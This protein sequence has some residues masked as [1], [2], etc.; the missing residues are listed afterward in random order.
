VSLRDVTR[1]FGQRTVLDGL[2]LA[3]APGQ[4]TALMGP[5]ASG[6][7]TVAR[8]VLGLDAPDTGRVLGREGLRF[9]AV[10]QE[11][12]LCEHLD[13]VENLAL[14]LERSER[15]GIA[16]ALRDVGLDAEALTK[17]VRELSGGQRRRVAIARALV[18]ESDLVVL[19]EP[20]TGIDVETKAT[21]VTYVRER[22]RG[23]TALLITHDRLEAAQLGATV[24]RLGD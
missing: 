19:D 4:V 20:F 10:F 15:A 13:A 5:N 22:L 23:R 18:C 3:L 11:D 21:L 8:L 1:R 24:V 12:R 16:D 7:T 9:A 2:N 14:V 17:P 6:K